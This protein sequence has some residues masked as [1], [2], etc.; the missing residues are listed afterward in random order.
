MKNKTTHRMK[1][2]NKKIG[3]KNGEKNKVTKKKGRHIKLTKK[4]IKKYYLIGGADGDNNNCNRENNSNE[5]NGKEGDNTEFGGLDSEY[6]GDVYDDGEDDQIPNGKDLTKRIAQMFKPETEEFETDEDQDDTNFTAISADVNRGTFPTIISTFLSQEVHDVTPFPNIKLLME[7]M[8][9]KA[10]ELA[11][12][13]NPFRYE[14]KPSSA[15]KDDILSSPVKLYDW[16]V[17]KNPDFLPIRQQTREYIDG[18]EVET[19]TKLETYNKNIIPNKKAEVARYRKI[20]DEFIHSKLEEQAQINVKLGFD[21]KNKFAIRFHLRKITEELLRLVGS[22]ETFTDL[23]T[24]PNLEQLPDKVKIIPSC[25]EKLDPTKNEEKNCE[26]ESSVDNPTVAGVYTWE[27]KSLDQSPY[28]VIKVPEYDFLVM[29]MV[30][31]LL[32]VQFLRKMPKQKNEPSPQITSLNDLNDRRAKLLQGSIITDKIRA[33][34]LTLLKEFE[35]L[36]A[37]GY[38]Y[39]EFIECLRNYLLFFSLGEHM[40]NTSKTRAVMEYL[41]SLTNTCFIVLPTFEQINFFKTV[42]LCAAP[43]L[44]LRLANTRVNVHSKDASITFE[45]FHDLLI[46]SFKSH[47]ISKYIPGFTGCYLGMHA[48]MLKKKFAYKY[49]PSKIKCMYGV[50]FRR[51]AELFKLY[52]H[53]T[54][55]I[56]Q[57]EMT[58]EQFRAALATEGQLT[59]EERYILTFLLFFVFH[60]MRNFCLHDL[61]FNKASLRNIFDYLLPKSGKF[62]K[63]ITNF[64]YSITSSYQPIFMRNIFTHKHCYRDELNGYLRTIL[65]KCLGKLQN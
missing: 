40:M 10:R 27:S 31:D 47:Q 11:I 12:P 14:H 59:N 55:E 23:L 18:L 51:I 64:Y 9:S 58:L 50:I 5:Y 65:D 17:S 28:P 32:L 29:G 43:V 56:K 41:R 13:K 57:S 37:N 34:A 1:L 44:N 8:F 20:L 6:G 33:K 38:L 49:Q 19:A 7:S 15:W 22:R 61:K 16:Y 63:Y 52:E 62:S 46:H 48:Y 24:Q 3:K 25:A 21:E 30:K 39:T 36:I 60:E 53:N 35:S 2:S 54:E 42:N 26:S 4:K 45:V